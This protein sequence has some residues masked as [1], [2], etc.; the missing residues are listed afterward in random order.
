MTT[1]NDDV[2]DAGAEYILQAKSAKGKVWFCLVLVPCCCTLFCSPLLVPVGIEVVAIGVM[3]PLA[4]VLAQIEHRFV[5]LWTALVIFMNIGGIGDLVADIVLLVKGVLSYYGIDTF[6]TSS[7]DQVDETTLLFIRAILT[8]GGAVLSIILNS[9]VQAITQPIMALVQ[10]KRRNA[11]IRK[12]N[13]AKAARAKAA[14]AAKA[15]A[16]NASSAST[17]TTATTTATAT[18]SSSTS[19]TTDNKSKQ[20]PSTTKTTTS[21]T[22]QSKDKSL[23]E[24]MFSSAS[25][26]L[27][28]VVIVVIWKLALILG[29][30]TIVVLNSAKLCFGKF[31]SPA[32]KNLLV[33]FELVLLA[34]LL[35]S[36][37][38]LGV[39]TVFELT[40]YDTLPIDAAH[41][42]EYI[43]L[44]AL[45]L[46]VIGACH[47]IYFEAFG[48]CGHSHHQHQ[49]HSHLPTTTQQ[50][51]LRITQSH[52]SINEPTAESI[53]LINGQDSPVAIEQV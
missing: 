4:W 34:D 7:S 33:S 14:A 12:A 37:I 48:I 21:T 29:R 20:T 43:K 22:A 44:L 42:W 13:A 23:C 39:L 16:N 47:L 18:S 19:T 46:D 25:S 6:A 17:T 35:T 53:P 38:P 32:T 36:G 5:A 40:T 10:A 45:A 8:L 41:I 11:A 31:N 52:T 9:T 2:R 28:L 49:Q 30:L 50:P 26:S 51:Q 24:T 15:K 3:F 27:G 1:L